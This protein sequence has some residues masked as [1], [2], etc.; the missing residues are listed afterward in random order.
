VTRIIGLGSPYG[1]DQVGWRVI[2]LLRGRLPDAIDLLALD[3][4]GAALIN[5]MR[6]VEH[7]VLIDAVVSGE[8]PGSLVK[9]QPAD[10]QPAN[11]R[12]SSHSLAL[13]DA[14]QLA[15]RLDCLPQRVDIYG[16]ELAGCT[17][18]E[19]SAEAEAG[20]NELATQ[21]GAEFS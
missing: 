5:W 3:R 14:F 11:E 1:D 20:A 16:I 18:E 8:T 10:L 19:L 21:I 7:L 15:E 9:L 6:Q 13:T 12:L 17:D 4:P 2:E